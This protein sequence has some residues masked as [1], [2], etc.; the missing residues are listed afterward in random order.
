MSAKYIFVTGGVLSSLGKGVASSSIGSII[1][2]MGYKIMMKKMD[3]YLNVDPGTLNPYEHG[4]AFV[5][6]DGI[7]TDLDLGHYERFTGVKTSRDSNITTGRIYE[8]IIKKE[9]QGDYGGKTVQVVPH[10]INE[11]KDFIKKGNENTDFIICEIGGTVGDIEV[12]PFLEAARQIK[13]EF[14]ILNVAHIH[15]TLIPYIKTSEELKTK[16]TQ[17]SVK[18]LLGSGIQPDFLLCRTEKHLSEEL[19]EKISLFCNVKPSRIIEAI[20]TKLIYEIPLLFEKQNISGEI[21]KH[22]NLGKYVKPDLQKIEIFVKKY[23][24]LDKSK[25]V[26]IGIIGKYVT[27]KDA[28]K[29]LNEALVNSGISNSIYVNLEWVDSEKVSEKDLSELDGI[30]VPGGFGTRGVSGKLFAIQ[31]A[32]EK[33]IPFLGICF[34][35][36]LSV[37]EFA[38]NVLKLHDADSTEIAP[39][40]KNPVISLISD[41][42]KVIGEDEENYLNSNMRLGAYDCYLLDNSMASKIYATDLITE[43]HRHKYEINISYKDEL[44]KHGLKFSGFS[45]NAKLTEI[46]EIPGHRWFIAVQFHPEFNSTPINPS[47]LFNSFLCASRD[48]S[49]S[50]DKSNNNIDFN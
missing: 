20:D 14:G 40:T 8:S 41:L 39:N 23:S 27:L 35:M 45:K 17:N 44:E 4:E 21:T 16:P 19:K 5:T 42:K 36:Q 50:T 47:P 15:L 1:Q 49:I 18:D 3:P 6:D 34:G 48:Y 13:N 10:V 22:F 37:I 25:P 38:R 2:A 43:R 29:S 33:N 12:L 26:K 9:R 30:V 7:E 28:Y 46:V 24:G 32:R 31:Y 11:I